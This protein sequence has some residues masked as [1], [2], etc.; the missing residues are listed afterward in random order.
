[1]R[2]TGILCIASALVVGFVIIGLTGGWVVALSAAAMIAISGL[3]ALGC[4]LIMEA[5]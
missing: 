3:L 4:I 2:T 5:D 1:M